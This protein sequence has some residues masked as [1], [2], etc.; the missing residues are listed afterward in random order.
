[1]AM[2]DLEAL[3]ACLDGGPGHEIEVDRELGARAMIPLQRMV[4]FSR[5]R[6]R[7]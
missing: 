5:E 2:N 6:A 1:M 3:L 7:A 4:N